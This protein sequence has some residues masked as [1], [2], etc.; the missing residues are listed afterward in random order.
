LTFIA[1]S[2]SLF[3]LSLCRDSKAL[4]LQKEEELLESEKSKK[5]VHVNYKLPD[6]NIIEVGME[7]FNAPEVL[8]NPELIGEEYP[9]IHETITNSIQKVLSLSS[10]LAH[11]RASVL[12]CFASLLQVD[13]DL[14]NVLYQNIVLSGGSTL[15]PGAYMIV[16]FVLSLLSASCARV[17]C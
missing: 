13:V 17:R 8:F 5:P 2:L 7:R 4:P 16:L 15:F 11:P 14:R 3:S 6:G 10:T 12:I 9:G 1:I